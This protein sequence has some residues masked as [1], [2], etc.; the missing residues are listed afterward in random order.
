MASLSGEVALAESMDQM[1]SATG[2][3]WLSSSSQRPGVCSSALQTFAKLWM[4]TEVMWPT[5]VSNQQISNQRAK[6][7]NSPPYSG[8]ATAGMPNNN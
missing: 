5:C 8:D 3:A 1:G 7:R 2:H 6:G 4:L